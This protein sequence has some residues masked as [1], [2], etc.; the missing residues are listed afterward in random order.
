MVARDAWRDLRATVP[1]NVLDDVVKAVGGAVEALEQGDVDRATALLRWAKSVASRTATIRETLGIAHYTAA[2]YSEAHSELLAYRRMSGKH[3]Q[4]HVLADCARA[5]GRLDKAVA[6]VEEMTAAGVDPARV[7][8]GVMVLAG[9][10]AD[11]NDLEGALQTLERLGLDPE[12]IQPWHPRVWYL[13]A[14]LSERLGRT[15]D[16]RD[17]FE[18]ITAVDDDFGDVAERLGRL[19]S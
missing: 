6:Y 2:R 15:S 11:A 12:E 1:P 8:E 3:D 10:R 18:A 14:D 4:N 17:Y 9:A 19:D 7:A 5:A 16:A 13:A